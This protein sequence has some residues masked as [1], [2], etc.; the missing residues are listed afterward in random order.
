MVPLLLIPVP[1]L[2]IPGVPDMLLPLF[3]PGDMLL[4][5]WAIAGIANATDITAAALKPISRII[6][7]LSWMHYSA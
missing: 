1:L 6:L 2:F 5:D 4:V 7:C 3:K